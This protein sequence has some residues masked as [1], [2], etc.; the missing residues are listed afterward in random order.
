MYG[1]N[2]PLVATSTRHSRRS[3]LRFALAS[4]L[5][6]FVETLGVAAAAPA[7][8]DDSVDF[9]GPFPNLYAMT[10]ASSTFGEKPQ[11]GALFGVW[12]GLVGDEMKPLFGYEGHTL[13]QSRI[14]P[15]DPQKIETR[16][17]ESCIYTD[18]ASGRRLESWQ[19]PYTGEVVPV[20]PWLLEFKCGGT[21]AERKESDF[22]TDEYTMHVYTGELARKGR[23]AADSVGLVLPWRRVADKYFST[24]HTYNRWPNPVTP[25][26]WPKASTGSTYTQYEVVRVAVDA[27]ALD[28]KGSTQVPRT[29]SLTR[30]TPWLPFMR[31]GQSPVKG[32]LMALSHI[33][34]LTGTI[35]DVPRTLRNFLEKSHPVMLEPMTSWKYTYTRPGSTWTSYANTV[36]PETP[37]YQHSPL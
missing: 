11:F 29:G 18:L 32:G 6:P 35:D 33:Y 19:N 8:S 15:D 7:A 1:T 34:S 9:G 13:A 20:H 31:M 26:G 2:W 37:G 27:N 14:S 23:N 4:G 30:R 22:A 12:Y 16:V 28:H 21:T 24:L 36:A 17:R 10:K 5:L 25:A 3:A